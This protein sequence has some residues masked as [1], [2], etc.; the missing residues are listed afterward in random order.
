MPAKEIKELRQSG[1]LAEA[2]EM[3]WAEYEL[4]PENIWTKRNLS[5]VYYEYLKTNALPDCYDDFISW[6]TKLA[7]LNLPEDEKMLFDTLTFQVGKL[8]FALLK[9]EPI[10]VQKIKRLADLI[11]IFHF[12]KPSDGYS[13]LLK[14]FHKGLKD[15]GHYLDFIDWWDL[16][17]LS[18]HDFEKEKLPT[19]K[20]IMALAEQIY[21]AYAKQLLPQKDLQGNV[22]FNRKKVEEFLPSLEALAENYPSYQY[23]PY[24]QAKLLLAL[25]DN[26]NVLSSLIPF[27]RKKQND[28]WVWEVLAEAVEQNPEQVFSCYC[29]GL[30]CPSPEVMLVG[31]RQ[32]MAESLIDRNLYNEAKTEIEQILGV[33]ESFGHKIPT[34]IAQWTNQPWYAEANSLE[35]NKSFYRQHTALAENI[36]YSDLSEELVFVEFVNSAKSMLHFI[37]SEEKFGFFKFDRFIKK[38]EPGDVLSIRFNGGSKGGRYHVLTCKKVT[39]DSFKAEFQKEVEGTVKIPRGASFGFLGDAFIH[40]S[41]VTKYQLSDGQDFKGQTIKTYDSKKE[42]WGW[43]L[44]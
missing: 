27:A 41:L 42:K 10:P 16:E 21:I 12:T 26:E 32:K 24:F 5:W 37:A 34:S 25:G 3:A 44:I 30:L 29:R 9:Q 7:E 40:P 18:P 31:L 4:D 17:N 43:K 33:K 2:L 13:F 38:V 22:Y 39:D 23:P 35:S 8:V 1:R 15:S 11:R 20:E 19:G 6:L 28:F 14:G 36:L